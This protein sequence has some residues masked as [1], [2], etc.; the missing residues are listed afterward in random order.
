M[1]LP[2]QFSF[3]NLSKL[4]KILIQDSSVGNVSITFT[5]LFTSLKPLSMIFV[6][7]IC[8]HLLNGCFIQAM[9]LSKSFL[10]QSA[11]LGN[12]SLYSL[13]NPLAFSLASLSFKAKYILCIFAFITNLPH[14]NQS[15]FD[16]I[17]RT[18]LSFPET[19]Q[20]LSRGN[21]CLPIG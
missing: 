18:L 13:I 17:C 10:I 19:I 4:Y 2:S 7:L 5:L 1:S 15:H 6:V 3:C 20:F 11:S 16:C 9:Q 21:M 12:I 14:K 8:L